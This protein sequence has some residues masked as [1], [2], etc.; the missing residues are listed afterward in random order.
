MRPKTLSV[1][2]LCLILLGCDGVPPNDPYPADQA[3]ENIYYGAFS[4][5]PK[6]LDPARSYSTS[7][8]VFTSQ[9]YEPPLQYAYKPGVYELI[10]DTATQM[11][12]ITYLNAAGESI[13]GERYPDQVTESIYEIT[14]Q[15]GILYQPHPALAKDEHGQFITHNLTEK[16]LSN[17]QALEDFAQIGTRE[18][19]AEDYVYEIKR[20]AWPR[21]NSPIYETMSQN[22]I[23]MRAFYD[24]IKD[25]NIGPQA[26]R[27]LPLEG[28]KAIDRYTYQIRLNGVYPQFKY[29]LAMPFFAPIPWE[30]DVFYEQQA[31]INKNIVLDWYPIGTGPYMMLENNPNNKIE[32]IQNPHY[33]G[34]T[35][36]GE[37]IP[38][39]DRAI[40]TLEKES[41]PR[42]N[43]FLQGYYDIS[44]IDS[45]NFTTAVQITSGQSKITEALQDKSISLIQEVSLADFYWGFN[46][47]DPVV[48]GYDSK[49]QKL[50]QA[51]SIAIDINEYIDIFLNGRGQ[52]ANFILPPGV[53]GYQS[54]SN[55]YV[56]GKTIEDARKLLAEAGY[57]NGRDAKTNVP[58]IIHFDT[59]SG[60]G[61]Q[62]HARDAWMRKQ[63]KKL[64]IDLDIRVTDYNR[65]RQKL[66]TGS[67][68][69]FFYGWLGDYP[70][71]ENF[72]FLLY[73]PY[74]KRDNNGINST[75]YDNPRY[76]KLFEK[77]VLLPDNKTR[78]A[79]IHEMMK[80]AQ[81]DAPMVWGFY[82]ETYTLKHDW[83][84][85]LVTN[86]MVRNQLKYLNID[87]PS[88]A[89]ARNT[90]NQPKIWPFLICLAV[91][92]VMIFPVWLSY[93]L[94]E[95]TGKTKRFKK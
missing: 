83:L 16:Q 63:F 50:R 85:N 48:G 2:M 47:G 41:I 88:R 61:P 79:V 65:F 32:L 37:K 17:I 91:I 55:P 45:D 13:D 38:K 93:W 86:A 54:T 71:P 52:E 66:D 57:P 73:G 6:Y 68:Q 76:N 18:L 64:G 14:I 25:K 53:F 9:I 40:Y 67:F 34:Q 58:L 1:I 15:P 28:A 12:K 4:G 42:W 77:M 26:L 7:E 90:W 46:M 35:Y 29:W 72:L 89:L 31:L 82:P 19:V 3:T 74:G 62:D 92:F 80:I 95:H 22:I 21:L 24:A 59:T 75:N 30:A 60:G 87:G 56:K 43:K 11:P 10:P 84:E 20:L 81:K 33:R 36:Q 27:D 44:G 69:F 8:S 70:D 5:R 39:I 49:S 94:K 23:G 78:E 51:I